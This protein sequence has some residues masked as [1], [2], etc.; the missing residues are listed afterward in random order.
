MPETSNE[1]SSVE[2]WGLKVELQSMKEKFDRELQGFTESEREKALATAWKALLE[3][4]EKQ[5][6]LDETTA[7][8][9]QVLSW[10]VKVDVKDNHWTITIEQNNHVYNISIEWTKVDE[11]KPKEENRDQAQTSTEWQVAKAWEVSA[12]DE[13]AAASTT[14]STNTNETVRTTTSVP[15]SSSNTS[16]HTTAATVEQS[17]A[18]AGQTT[19]AKAEQPAAKTVEQTTE[20]QQT[21]TTYT[22]TPDA[23]IDTPDKAA[24]EIKNILAS[25]CSEVQP[26]ATGSIV[27]SAAQMWKLDRINSLRY[28]SFVPAMPTALAEALGW[29]WVI[30]A[31]DLKDINL[32][33]F[34]L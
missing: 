4:E 23:Q 34:I 5:K 25:L 20:T 31:E 19:V 2:L 15:A 26:D 32:L 11:E 12:E 6:S 24:E 10:D 33:T 18:V 14:S 28:R 7:L 8:Q 29:S 27:L 17:T 21:T 3:L 13:E 22:E 1:K 30:T 16:T 9:N